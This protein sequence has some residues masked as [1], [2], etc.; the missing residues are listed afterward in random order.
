MR[1]AAAAATAML[2]GQASVVAAAGSRARRPRLRP[3]CSICAQESASRRRVCSLRSGNSWRVAAAAARACAA[4]GW[5]GAAADASAVVLR[6]QPCALTV[7]PVGASSTPTAVAALAL[8]LTSVVHRIGPEQCLPVQCSAV[9]AHL[10]AAGRFRQRAVGVRLSGCQQCS[11]LDDMPPAALHLTPPGRRPR[12]STST[13]NCTCSVATLTNTIDEG[14]T[15][16]FV[17]NNL[18]AEMCTPRDAT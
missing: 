5:R 13:V 9:P 4:D 14:S 15:T 2:A 7:M 18:S 17:C 3:P 8:T 6:A 16:A 11:A 12:G 1:G 10:H